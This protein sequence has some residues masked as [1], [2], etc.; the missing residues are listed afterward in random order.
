[1]SLNLGRSCRGIT[2][3]RNRV[4]RVAGAFWWLAVL[5]GGVALNPK[6]SP[7]PRLTHGGALGGKS[8]AGL[9][10]QLSDPYPPDQRQVT[11][12]GR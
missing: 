4:L 8:L 3:A 7:R 9:V 2:H 1:M 10:A 11:Y 12:A 5:R 6:T